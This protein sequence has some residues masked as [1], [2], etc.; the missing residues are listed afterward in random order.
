MDYK[1]KYL[2]YKQKYLEL[3]KQIGGEDAVISKYFYM[4]SSN[5]D[6]NTQINTI[7]SELGGEEITKP[8]LLAYLGSIDYCR[9]GG[10]P[11]CNLDGWADLIIGVVDTKGFCSVINVQTYQISRSK[12]FFIQKAISDSRTKRKMKVL[13]NNVLIPLAKSLR[14]TAINT[15]HKDDRSKDFWKHMGFEEQADDTLQ[16]KLVK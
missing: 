14:L 3:K 12:S 9:R 6:V 10:N 5:S 2:K 16:L 13:I 8:Q 7:I 1:Q 15:T 11:F 4:R